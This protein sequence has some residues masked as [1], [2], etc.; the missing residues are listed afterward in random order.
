MTQ[1]LIHPLT[2]QP[3]YAPAALFALGGLLGCGASPAT[4]VPT[5]AAPSS[6]S[7]S[8]H[9]GRQPVTGSAI[10]VWASG[11]AGT[12]SGAVSL[13][14]TTTDANGNF[15]I[16]PGT[17]SCTG[18]TPLYITAQ[19]GNPGNSNSPANPNGNNPD[20]FFVAALGPCSPAVE[21]AHV[22]IDEVTTVATALTF[23]GAINAQNFGSNVNFG[24]ADGIGSTSAS[25]LSAALA[26]ASA[27]ANTSSGTTPG[28]ALL[29][30]LATPLI[31]TLADILAACANSDPLNGSSACATVFSKASPAPTTSTPI[32]TNTFEA[33]VYLGLNP[34]STN[35][36]GSNVSALYSL[37]PPQAPYQPAVVAAP[38]SWA[39][40]TG[41]SVPTGALNVPVPANCAYF[42]AW[43]N[44]AAGGT[45]PANVAPYTATLEQQAGRTLALHMHYYGWGTGAATVAGSTPAFPDQAMTDDI[46]AGR[47]PVVTWSCSGTNSVVG[48]ASPTVD[49]NAYNL[50]VATAQAVKAFGAPVFLRWNWEMNLV[51]NNKCMDSGTSAQQEAGYI[52]AWQNIYNI[53]KAQGVT[54]VSWLWNPAG[55]SADPTS[56]PY[57]PGNAYVD[58]IG[59]DG[60][61]KVNAYDFGGVFS[62]FYQQV[63][64]YGKP[65]LIA[66]TGECSGVQQTYLNSAVA[67]IAGRSN[68]GGYSFPLVAGFMYFDAPGQ[69]GACT[70]N[71]DAEGI[72]GF[73]AMGSDPYFVALTH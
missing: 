24:I 66:E 56:I 29:P 70:W 72:T 33:A 2:R 60:Y 71:F 14:T 1:T 58:W 47:T 19:G 6:L 16:A 39:V 67:E 13:A 18:T 41:C 15:S 3:W 44:P 68:T 51:S 57:Y 52:A 26:S 50:I 20:L 36:S 49:V 8:V 54:N 4:I 32:A 42:G 53:F 62:H 25:T 22:D 31:N 5:D 9:G 10:T 64:A 37:V 46:A 27:M 11:S 7:G 43:A 21:S 61:D 69:Y 17:Y 59:F 73:A 38:A 34:T 30:T 45:S 23:G 65:I 40:A 63:Q 55:A 12:G 35:A 48:T 28:P